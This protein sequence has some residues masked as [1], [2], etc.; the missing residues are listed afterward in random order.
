MS[1]PNDIFSESAVAKAESDLPAGG[2][3]HL[4]RSP[5]ATCSNRYELSSVSFRYVDRAPVGNLTRL[6]CNRRMTDRMARVSRLG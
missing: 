6:P 2:A 4:I 5:F 3:A 1:P